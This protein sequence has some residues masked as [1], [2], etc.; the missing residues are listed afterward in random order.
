MSHI[1]PFWMSVD[2]NFSGMMDN[3]SCAGVDFCPLGGTRR[4]ARRRSRTGRARGKLVEQ[5]IVKEEQREKKQKQKWTWSEQ[6]IWREVTEE[7]E[8]EEKGEEGRWA[9][10]CGAWWWW[11]RG[12][13]WWWCDTNRDA[14]GGDKHNEKCR[15]WW[16]DVSQ[17][18]I[19]SMVM[20]TVLTSGH[21]SFNIRRTFLNNHYLIANLTDF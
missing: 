15:W 1:H 14:G 7:E 18:K 8:T 2:F 11:W 19:T 6:K 5:N 12:Y 20:M 3:F 10:T 21:R 9:R 16:S 13:W 17:R 4:R